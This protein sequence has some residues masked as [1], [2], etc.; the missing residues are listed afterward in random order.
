[1]GAVSLQVGTLR[2]RRAHELKFCSTRIQTCRHSRLRNG[3][4]LL[5]A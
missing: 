2:I 4:S 1:M 3:V 5:S